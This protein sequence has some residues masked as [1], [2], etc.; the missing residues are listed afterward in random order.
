MKKS[1]FVHQL[2]MLG[3]ANSVIGDLQ[4]YAKGGLPEDP[5]EAA[6]AITDKLFDPGIRDHIGH[7]LYEERPDSWQ[8]YNCPKDGRMIERLRHYGV[9]PFMSLCPLCRG[10]RQSA[11]VT[12][13]SEGEPALREWVRPEPVNVLKTIT[14][15]PE[16]YEHIR[17]GGLVPVLTEA[18]KLAGIAQTKPRPTHQ[19]RRTDQPGRNSPCPCGSGRKHKKCCLGKE[20]PI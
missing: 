4:S 7:D 10:M 5:E 17:M 6:Q 18:G 11:G 20:A 8:V 3:I 12:Q 19:H 13:D 1:T 16:S 14:A 2:G 9:T 15:E